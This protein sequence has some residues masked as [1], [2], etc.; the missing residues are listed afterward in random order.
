MTNRKETLVSPEVGA[1]LVKQLAHELKN[2]NLYKSFAAF[3]GREGITDLEEYFNES[4]AEEY[5]HHSWVFS[6]LANSDYKFSYPAI[7]AN[8]EVASEY[9]VPFEQALAREIQ[10]TQLL[11]TLYKQCIGEDDFMTASWLSEKLIKEQIEEENKSRMA[12]DIITAD[13]DIFVRAHKILDL[14]G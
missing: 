1:L 8:T 13:A 5:D 14:L 4:A 12:L 2:H 11:Y 6:Y 3:F 9:I 7:E 10:T